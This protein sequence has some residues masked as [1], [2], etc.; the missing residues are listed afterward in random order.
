MAG[1]KGR[2]VTSDDILAHLTAE[3]GLDA[4][5]KAKVQPVIEEASEQMAVLPPGTPQRRDVFRKC[6]PRIR[7]VLRPDQYPVL[8]RFVEMAERRWARMIRRRG[9]MQGGTTQDELPPPK[10]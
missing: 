5:Q 7:E 2:T 10:P 3:L 4:G 8:E 9:A 1:P 6:I